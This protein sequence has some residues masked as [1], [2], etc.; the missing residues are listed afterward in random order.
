[1]KEYNGVPILCA[2]AIKKQIGFSADDDELN[3][4][5]YNTP[6][7][8]IPNINKYISWSFENRPTDGKTNVLCGLTSAGLDKYLYDDSHE[9][10]Y[11]NKNNH[12][13]KPYTCNTDTNKCHNPDVTGGPGSNGD[14]CS[15]PTDCTSGYCNDSGICAIK[16]SGSTGPLPNGSTCTSNDKCTSGYC[17]DSKICATNS[18]PPASTSCNPACADDE[19]CKSGKCVAKTT[20]PP[21]KKGLSKT[22]III[23]SVSA[24]VLL[25]II[26]G[27]FMAMRNRK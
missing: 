6:D 14:T 25:L 23:I 11:C 18:D 26:L 16:P 5:H 19:T 15:V 4:W 27:I 17:N 3:L 13:K 21:A 2:R 12:C 9:G 7:S 8:D 10:T 24:G 20:T 1:M 22:W